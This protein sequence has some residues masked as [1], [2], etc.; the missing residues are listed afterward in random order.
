META[1]KRGQIRNI[2][3]SATGATGSSLPVL[4]AARLAE[5]SVEPF[6][7]QTVHHPAPKAQIPLIPKAHNA[8]HKR[9][10][11]TQQHG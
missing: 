8:N 2:I 3:L 9:Q 5:S 7:W 11:Q 1:V 10:R 4:L 6:M